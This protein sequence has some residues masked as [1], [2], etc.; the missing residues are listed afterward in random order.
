MN[1]CR[2]YFGHNSAC[3]HGYQANSEHPIAKAVMDYSKRLRHSFGSSTD[4]LPEVK[5]F[6]VHTGAGVIGKV[7][8]KVVAVGNR[9]LMQAFNATVGRK[10]EDYISGNERLARTCVL[11]AIDGKVAGAFAVTDPVKPEAGCVISFLHSM[12][13]SSIMATGD[14]WATATAIAKEIGIRKVF[15]ETDPVGKAKI[16]KEMQVQIFPLHVRRIFSISEHNVLIS[17]CYL[18]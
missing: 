14:N 3:D 16:I 13:I 6:E 10:V 17:H 8:E 12:G 1:I 15:A 2:N 4:H 18:I 7:G 9:R 11:V 5:D